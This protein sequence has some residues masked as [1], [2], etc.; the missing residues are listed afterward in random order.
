MKA[1]KKDMKTAAMNVAVLGALAAM[2]A[3]PTMAYAD[4]AEEIAAIRRPTN[5]VEIGAENVGKSSAKFGEYNGLNEDGVYGIANFSVKGGDAYDGGDGTMRWGVTGTD[6]GTTS[7]EFK[8]TIGNQGKWNLG[9]GYDQLQRNTSDSYQSPYLGSVGGNNFTLPAGFGLVPN[10]APGTD[11]LTAAQKAAFRTRDIDNT[12]KNT[13]F[14]A[15]LNL[16]PQWDIKFEFNR[17]DQSGAKLRAFGTDNLG[18]GNGQKIAILPDPTNYQTDTVNLGLNWVGDNGYMTVGYFGSYFR[19]DY[20][21][22]TF[23]NFVGSQATNTMTTPPDNNLHQFNLTGGYDLAAKTKLTGGFSYSRNTQDD[24]FVPS[25]LTQVYNGINSLNGKVNTTHAD[26]KLTDRSF[27]DL[28]L[29]AGIKYDKR[30]NETP[31]HI[32]NF[33]AIDGG[34]RAVYPNTPLSIRKTQVEL[35]AEYRLDKSQKILL[36]LTHDDTNR[37]CNNYAV[38]AL[39][40][41]GTNCVVAEGA[42][43]DKLSAGYRWKASDDVNLNATYSYGK[44]NTD[45]DKY[46][47]AAMIGTNGGYVTGNPKG[48]NAGDFFGFHP[49]FDEDRTQ[50]MLKAGV[51]WQANE[52]TTVGF[53]A[54]YTDDN[55]DTKY[56][57]KNGNQWSLSL[58]GAY[59]YSEAGLVTAYVTQ[60][61]RYRDRTDLR[62]LNTNTASSATAI[63]VPP[64]STVNG[65][66]TDEDFTIGLGFKQGKLMDGK[67]ELLGDLTYSIGN[68][69]YGTTLNWAGVTLPTA[70]VV[71]TCASAFLLS[72]GGLPSVKNAMTQV[73]L[74]GTYELDKSSKI[75]M[76][77]RYQRLDSNDYY[78]NGLQYGNTPISLM[79]TNQNSGSYSVNLVAVSYMYSFK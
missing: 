33:F 61:R 10:A 24:S 39:Y 46:A 70:G 19:D 43:E 59:S 75:A 79:P 56:G 36:S 38:S 16:S 66:L 11:S 60:Q 27:K 3:V 28:A 14:T 26:L 30:D 72:C 45:F 15:G 2:C 20:D 17:L 51:N 44:R 1:H 47:R 32:Y 42:T 22:V 49:Y 65:T 41:P 50:Q 9:I 29:S 57:W 68:T 4:S 34:N 48:Q 71:S 74:T 12:R 5:F 23:S 67:L 54:K 37:W 73:K 6:L 53:T 13:S 62:N 69:D 18:G 55:Y 63:N 7:R 40:P 21:R 77:Y 58:D 64:Y 25:G 31:S 8:A 52:Q 76:G 35:A 78:Y